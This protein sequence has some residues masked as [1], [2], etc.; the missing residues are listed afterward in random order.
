M[1]AD[2]KPDLIA[3]PE[4]E[5]EVFA[6]G[7]IRAQEDFILPDA[8]DLIERHVDPSSGELLKQQT[9]VGEQDDTVP[10][11]LRVAKR[12]ATIERRLGTA[13]SANDE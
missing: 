7:P 10:A 8:G 5:Y 6:T 4:L 9:P 13:L 3:V 2:H 1:V 12:R 11:D